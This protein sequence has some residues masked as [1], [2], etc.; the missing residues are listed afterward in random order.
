MKAFNTRDEDVKHIPIGKINIQGHDKKNII[1]QDL[2]LLQPGSVYRVDFKATLNTSTHVLSSKQANMALKIKQWK[3]NDA[4]HYKRP[5]KVDIGYQLLTK[6]YLLPYT[7]YNYDVGG[8]DEIKK[9]KGCRELY[10]NCMA[11]TSDMNC[12]WDGAQLVCT[13][14]REKAREISLQDN[15]AALE[16]QEFLKLLPDECVTC[17]NHIYCT[18]CVKEGDGAC[19]WIEN[20]LRDEARC[21]RKGRFGDRV[22][23]T[24][25]VKVNIAA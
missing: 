9:R 7:Y 6:R 1:Q 18:T 8:G 20:P 5:T 11:C 4:Q 21:I 15:S 13:N 10:S 2:I 16:K 17:D 22:G 25:P 12:G 3:A 14:R 23:S 19:E 24:S